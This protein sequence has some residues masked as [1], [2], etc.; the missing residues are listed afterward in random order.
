MGEAFVLFSAFKHIVLRDVKRPTK[1][2][3]QR[4]QGGPLVRLPLQL[5]YFEI[6][7]TQ[8][9]LLIG[10]LFLQ[11]VILLLQL[12]IFAPKQFRVGPQLLLQHL[13]RVLQGF[14]VLQ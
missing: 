10:E 9:L 13:L 4:F 14:Y 11:F 1:I 8:L 6:A 7:D 2:I 5:V 3:V 12:A